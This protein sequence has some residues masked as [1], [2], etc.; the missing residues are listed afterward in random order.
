MERPLQLAVPD[1]GPPM[2]REQ[3]RAREAVPTRL[4]G[5]EEK[6][7]HMSRKSWLAV[8]L[9]LV[10]GA[11]LAG[12]RV[13]Q[14]EEGKLPEVDVDVKE[15]ELPAYDVDAPDVDV[16]TEKREVTVPTDV[17]V[18]TEKR[19]VEVPADVDLKYEDEKPPPP[20]QKPPPPPQ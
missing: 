4:D 14:T 15:G 12:C 16:K 5:S 1:S 9:A 3:Q 17:D 13:Q 20:P 18:K 7:E 19:E 8:P 11:G 10:L 6:G 2:A